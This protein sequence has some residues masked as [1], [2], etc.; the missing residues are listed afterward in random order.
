MSIAI[1]QIQG[2]RV[3]ATETKSTSQ[4]VTVNTLG[5]YDSSG[6]VV[7]ATSSTTRSQVA[8]IFKATQTAGQALA[9]VEVER[10][11]PTSTYIMN[12]TNNSSAAHDGQAMVL[13]DAATLN[14]TGTTAAAGLF[15]QIGTVGAAA[16]K[17]ILVRPVT[18]V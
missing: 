17:T 2:A 5:A 15:I 12:T 16:D 8:G 6:N 10:L 1:A 14:N 9:T 18:S 11:D 4:A 3:N 7:P 13:T